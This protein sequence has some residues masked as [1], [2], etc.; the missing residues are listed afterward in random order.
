MTHD[1]LGLSVAPFLEMLL[2][3]RAS[4]L[5]RGHR[6]DHWRHDNYYDMLLELVA[7]PQVAYVATDEV[8]GVRTEQQCYRN[9]YDA[10]VQ[11]RGYTYCEGL[12]Q[13]RGDF[14]F[15][16]VVRHAWLEDEHGRIIDPTWANLP[17]GPATYYGLKF[18]DD[19]VLTHVL[20][21]GTTSFIDDDWRHGFPVLKRGFTFDNQGRANGLRNPPEGAS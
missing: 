18:T 20:E 8:L 16:L 13:H 12:A 4:I 17:P 7:A 19:F 21:T 9:A 14:A 15:G 6:P 10:I 1:T 5:E 2:A 3:E 11:Y